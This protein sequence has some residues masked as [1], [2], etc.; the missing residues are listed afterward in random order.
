MSQTETSPKGQKDI[1]HHMLR[2]GNFPYILEY[3]ELIQLVQRKL[4]PLQQLHIQL[5]VILS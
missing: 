1:K 5:V 4:E 3:M 2:I